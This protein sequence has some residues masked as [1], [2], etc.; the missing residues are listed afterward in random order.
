MRRTPRGHVGRGVRF[1][2]VL[3][4]AALLVLACANGRRGAGFEVEQVYGQGSAVQFTVRVSRQRISTAE[5][6]V[7]VLEVRAAED[8]N[9][10]FPDIADSLGE[11]TVTERAGEQRRLDR[12]RNLISTRRYTLEPFLPARYTIPPLEVHF[13]T[14]GGYPFSLRSQELTIEVTSVL[15]PQ[16]GEQDIEQIAGPV[17][18]RSRR[19]LWYGVGGGVLVM[20]A[21][22]ALVVLRRRRRT[23]VRTTVDK[24][25]WEAATEE[26]EALLGLGLVEAGRFRELYEGLSDLTRRYIERRFDIRAPELTTEEFLE[27]AR[28]SE[29]LAAQRESLG[30][31]LAH[32]DLVKFARYQPS[33]EEALA[34]AG[35]CREFLIATSPEA[36]GP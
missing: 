31:F 16:L 19:T 29:A 33:D 5:T 24:T 30:R 21:A 12:D 26:L 23:R 36:A 17:D 11:F 2:A 28:G 1:G 8:W 32:C 7:L 14:G 34:A 20:A 18:L 6:V 22:A 13:G 27:K 10:E 35:S 9:V 4:A 15:P 3:A 25:P